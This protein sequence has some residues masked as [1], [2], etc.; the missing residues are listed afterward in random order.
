MYAGS[1]GDVQGLDVARRALAL[2]SDLAETSGVRAG[3]RS[4]SRARPWHDWPATWGSADRVT[5]S[6]SRPVAEMAALMATADVQLVSLKDLPLFHVTMPSKVQAILAC[7]RPVVISAPGD[8]ADARTASG[9]GAG[10][11]PRGRDLLAEAIRQRA[12][13]CW[14]ASLEAMGRAGRDFYQRELV[15]VRRRCADG[16][17]PRGSRSEGG[18]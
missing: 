15:G 6:G 10:C 8:A 11:R 13:L 5:F 12:R 1:I 18:R 3:R 7:G 9:A 4:A 14:G 16:G 2:L 17:R